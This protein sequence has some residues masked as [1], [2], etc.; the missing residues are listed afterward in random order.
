MKVVDLNSKKMSQ[1]LSDAR[2]NAIDIPEL[3][4]LCKGVLADGT[5]NLAEAEF[6]QDW[7]S[8]RPNVLET[9][10]AEELGSLLNVALEDGKLSAEEEAELIDLLEE[11]TG[12]P[13]SVLFF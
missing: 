2:F 9:W 12:E 7:L 6:I 11:I 5:I 3:I 10:P 8:Q 4:G 13:V 1:R